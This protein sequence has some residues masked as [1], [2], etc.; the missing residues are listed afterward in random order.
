MATSHK[1]HTRKKL[2]GDDLKRAKKT[3]TANPPGNSGR[4]RPPGYKEKTPGN[5]SGH[6]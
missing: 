5:Y 4:N 2:T 3:D 6:C 1:K